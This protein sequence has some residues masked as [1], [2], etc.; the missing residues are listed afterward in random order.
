M[1]EADKVSSSESAPVHLAFKQFFF[2]V[3][4]DGFFFSLNK[5]SD[6]FF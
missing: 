6:L 1:K 3:E 5:V 2:V 4:D